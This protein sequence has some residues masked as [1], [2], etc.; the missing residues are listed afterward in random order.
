MHTQQGYN[1][2]IEVGNKN[3]PVWQSNVP[4]VKIISHES[5]YCLVTVEVSF[6][7]HHIMQFKSL[8]KSSARVQL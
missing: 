5:K 2:V 4:D 7:I 1:V 8:T 3:K 6:L